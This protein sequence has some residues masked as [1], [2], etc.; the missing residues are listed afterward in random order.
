VSFGF[1][2][3]LSFQSSFF[4]AAPTAP[5][6]Y[7]AGKS[8]HVEKL[9]ALTRIAREGCSNGLIHDDIGGQQPFV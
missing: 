7:F 6:L 9:D 2:F 4:G 8:A 5:H 3:I 1:I